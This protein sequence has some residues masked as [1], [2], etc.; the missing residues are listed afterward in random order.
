M[1]KAASGSGS[2][3]SPSALSGRPE[4]QQLMDRK[5]STVGKMKDA[6]AT[7]HGLRDASKNGIPLA[8][9]DRQITP[10]LGFIA[11]HSGAEEG[12]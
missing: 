6:N 5:S 11:R 3:E 1:A 7:R 4:E 9:N 2:Y 10:G 8:R 12:A